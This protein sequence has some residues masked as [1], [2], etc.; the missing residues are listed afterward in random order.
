MSGKLA[1][2]VL[3]GFGIF[4]LCVDSPSSHEKGVLITFL[5]L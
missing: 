3:F 5:I 1:S 2:V 4:A